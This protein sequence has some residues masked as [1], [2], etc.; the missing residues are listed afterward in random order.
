MFLNFWPTLT[1]PGRQFNE[2]FLW[3]KLCLK[4]RQSATSIQPLIDLLACLELKLWPKKNISP[5][6]QKNAK[7]ALNLQLASIQL[8]TTRRWNMLASYSKPRKTHEVLW[9]ELKKKRLGYEFGVFDGCCWKKGKFCFFN[10]SFM[11]SSLG[12][13][14]EIVAQSL[15]AF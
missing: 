7:N 8:A 11:T 1:G 9:F 3:L 2:P 10:C 4:I 14:A 15:V 12:Q 5:Q 6:N 13:W